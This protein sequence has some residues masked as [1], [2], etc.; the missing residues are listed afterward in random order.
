MVHVEI[1]LK[2]VDLNTLQLAHAE[3]GLLV[4]DRCVHINMIKIVR[5]IEDVIS[6][7]LKMT[8]IVGSIDEEEVRIILGVIDTEILIMKIIDVA[9]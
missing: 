9:I 7:P 4:R 3:M 5:G 2:R 6:H 1:R 8:K